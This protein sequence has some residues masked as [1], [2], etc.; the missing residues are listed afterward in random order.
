LANRVHLSDQLREITPEIFTTATAIVGVRGSGKTS[1]GVLLNEQAIAFGVPVAIIDPTGVWYGLKS[2]RDGK[3]PGLP[4]Y[5]FGGQHGDV[6]LEP[7]AGAVVARFVVDERVPIVLDLSDLSKTKQRRFVADFCEALY[8]LKARK[9]DPLLLTIDE[10]PRFCPQTLMRGDIELSRCVGAVEDIVSLG[11]SRGLGCAIIGQRSATINN[12]VLTQ[13][14]NLCAMRSIGTAD[15]KAID[16][17]VVEAQ[18]DQQQRD[19]MVRHLATLQ[20]GEG[21]F[22]SPAIF[23]VFRRVKFAQRTTFDSSRTPKVGEKVVAPKSF[24]TVDLE[25]LRG[26]IAS[27]VERAKADDPKALRAEVAD[28]KKKLAAAGTADPAEMRQLRDR[29]AQLEARPPERVE[30]PVLRDG[31]AAAL[32]AVADKLNAA[33]ESIVGGLNRII[34]ARS[35]ATPVPARPAPVARREPPRPTE[36]APARR[37]APQRAANSSGGPLGS[38]PMKIL[39]ALAG[40]P[41][42]RATRT[43]LGVI[44]GY[45]PN[46]GGFRNNLSALRQAGFI[47]DDGP[48]VEITSR[49]ASQVSGIV[50]AV[51]TRDVHDLWRAKLDGGPRKVLD[52]LLDAHPR[53]LTREELADRAGYVASA[54]G[55]RNNLS[56]LR[57]TDLIVE[58]DRQVFASDALFPTGAPR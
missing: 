39:A 25:K 11:R 53:G 10:V 37:E 6:P 45:S 32:G 4:V 46:A 22:W 24:A 9:R 36:S 56:A 23:G 35:A 27:A 20:Q 1:T 26:E 18:G 16:A 51:T 15:R 29:V 43:Q 8:D 30:V 48:I 54:G 5:V 3:S 52:V 57:T 58:R 47:R 17:W 38:G 41:D 55:F 50:A 28:L 19:E 21:Y 14:D 34:T 44:A 12:N 49:G 2:S 13:A 33:V 7:D 42:S 31:E 40:Y